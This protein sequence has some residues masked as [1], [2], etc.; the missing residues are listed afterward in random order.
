MTRAKLTAAALL[1][2]VATALPAAGAAARRHR[3][4]TELTGGSRRS[5]ARPLG[6]TP[7]TPPAGPA[8]SSPANASRS[9]ARGGMGYHY[10]HPGLAADRKL[11]PRAPE[12]LLY[13]PTAS[14]RMRLIAVEYIRADADQT[15]ETDDD[16]PSLFGVPFD[17]PMDGHEPGQ[18]VHYDLHA[19]VWKPNPSGTFAQ[20]N[21]DVR[22]PD[23]H[24]SGR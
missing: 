17:G 15:K 19:W 18:P 8:T 13:E 1:A 23:P 11:D 6:S 22:C 4:T 14:G 3:A 24:A 20:F 5:G 16:R 9:Q 7:C 2:L 21:P 10:V 12:A